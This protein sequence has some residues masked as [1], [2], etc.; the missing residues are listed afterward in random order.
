MFPKLPIVV[1][2]SCNDEESQ[3]RNECMETEASTIVTLMGPYTGIGHNK[4]STAD[5]ISQ[6]VKCI[7]LVGWTVKVIPDYIQIATSNNNARREVDD[8][9]TSSARKKRTKIDRE[10]I[11][12]SL[13]KL[14]DKLPLEVKNE[15]GTDVVAYIDT[16]GNDE[17]EQ[18][19]RV[20]C[21][22][23]QVAEIIEKQLKDDFV[24][25]KLEHVE[26]S[27]HFTMTGYT[28]RSK[29]TMTARSRKENEEL[30]TYF[31]LKQRG[32]NKVVANAHCSYQNIGFAGPTLELIETINEWQGRGLGASLLNAIEEFYRGTFANIL[33]SSEYSDYYDNIRLHACNTE[34]HEAFEWFQQRGFR[35]D[36]G[37]GEDLSKSLNEGNAAEEAPYIIRRCMGRTKH[38][39]RCKV[40]S[41]NTF[42]AA[43]TLCFGG[44]KFCAIHQTQQQEQKISAFVQ[45]NEDD[46]GIE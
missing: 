35:D 3:G 44:S 34:G 15:T 32:T 24:L 33:D 31:Q 11:Y 4:P 13:D 43:D 8:D 41:E 39:L 16:F 9:E 27:L 23:C 14:D 18:W 45:N 10:Y 19:I 42:P 17:E 36:T 38:A 25:G 40:T 26:R 5:T 22:S 46:N 37:T 2:N 12:L 6:A 1:E 29:T 21:N 20:E 30:K 28:L 7:R